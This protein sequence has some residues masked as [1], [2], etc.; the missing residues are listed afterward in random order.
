MTLKS[1]DFIFWAVIPCSLGTAQ[2]HLHLQGKLTNGKC[3]RHKLK[4]LERQV[5][6]QLFSTAHFHPYFHCQTTPLHTG[7]HNALTSNVRPMLWVAPSF[8]IIHLNNGDRNMWQNNETTSTHD[9]SKAPKLNSYNNMCVA[10]KFP[11]D[12]TKQ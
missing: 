5:S 10:H 3:N 7:Q 9:E 6:T 8:C 4:E 2:H 12:F 11:F 1:E